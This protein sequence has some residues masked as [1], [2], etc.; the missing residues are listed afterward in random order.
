MKPLRWRA[1]VVAIL[2]LLAAYAVAPTLIYFSQPLEVRND[3]E[4]FKAKLPK[5]LPEDHIKLGLDLQGGVMLVLGVSTDDAIANRLGRTS[6]ELT[7]WAKDNELSV[8]TAYVEKGKDRLVVLLAE[9]QDPGDFNEKF[10]Q[11]FPL[12]VKDTREER[13]LSYVYRSNELDRIKKSALEQAERVVRSRVDAW[14]VSEPMINRRADG[15]I[16]VQLPGFR[17]PSKAKELLGRT[18]QL[19]FKIVDD[20]FTGFEKVTA[21]LPEGITQSNNGGQVSFVSE[22]REALTALLSPHVPSDRL[23]LFARR[24]IGDG[25]LARYSWTSYVV[26]AASELLGH[27]ISDA[28]FIQAAGLDQQ[29]MVSLKLTA[30][31]GKRFADLTGAN[32]GKRL[33]I[34]L[35]NVIE[36]APVIQTKITGGNAQIT[37]GGNGRPYQE[38][39]D[40]GNELALVLKSGAIPATITVLEQRQVGASLGPEL[41]NQGIKGILFGLAFVLI[42]MLIYYRRPGAIACLALTLNGLFLLAVMAGFG[43]ALTLPGIAGFVLTLGMAVDANVLINERIR[44]EVREGKHPRLSVQVGF[45]KVFWTIIDANVT[46]L[47]AALVLL[48]TNPSGPIRGFAVTLM[49]GLIVSLFTSLYVSHVFFDL[50]VSRVHDK[51]LKAWLGGERKGR[52]FH[53]NFLR[54]GR[55][56]TLVFGLLS[57]FILGVTASRGLNFGVDFAGGTEL[58][59][60]FGVPVEAEEIRKLEQLE[61]IQN[62][63]LQALG[64]TK[65]Q[66]LVRYDENRSESGVDEAEASETFIAFKSALTEN[67]KQYEPEILQAD[68]VGPQVGK[69]LRNRGIISVFWAILAVLLYIALR[70]DMRFAPGAIVKMFLDIFI[71]LGF[72]SVFWA[73]FDLVAVAAFLTVVGYSV[74]DTIVIYDR[75]RENLIDHPRR[76]LRENINFALNETLSRTINTS[77]TTVVS[78]VGILIFGTGQIWNFAMAMSIGVVVATIS[79]ALVASSFVLWLENWRKHKGTSKKTS[80]ARA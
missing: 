26:F 41:A 23:L 38:I 10:G 74:N 58:T 6:V 48:E 72:Y 75:I 39:I 36:S 46:T 62:M 52:S 59:I 44:Q 66:Y 3:E 37:L 18:A 42:F 69:E 68:F 32:V 7:R 71:M 13:K 4:A 31:G 25:S 53:F 8:E 29:P 45:K 33:A 47:I 50:A 63:S 78:L 70:F 1:T 54:L 55:P 14:G 61:K 2:T 12:L 11:Q 20:K 28:Q 76:S 80:P 22:D 27:D 35:D 24:Q 34:V 49:I 9:G 21:P 57:V 17:D 77:L 5:F 65:K 40:D 43:F 15:S 67:L 73:S 64:Q 56:A 60:G 16:L 79:S 30:T 51:K 19:E